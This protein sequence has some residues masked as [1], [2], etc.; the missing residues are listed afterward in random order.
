MKSD[1]GRNREAE[2]RIVELV[3]SPAA[4]QRDLRRDV[5]ARFAEHGIV[6][7]DALLLGQPEQS[8]A[9]IDRQ[10]GGKIVDMILLQMSLDW[11]W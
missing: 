7:V 3:A 2:H 9:A 11:R 6:P 10:V 8:R 1:C 5:E 4:G